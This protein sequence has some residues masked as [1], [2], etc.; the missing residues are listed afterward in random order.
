MHI[1]IK[2]KSSIWF[3]YT[4]EYNVMIPLVNINWIFSKPYYDQ[5]NI[6]SVFS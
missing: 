1:I 2:T 3:I 4:M 5:I 6:K